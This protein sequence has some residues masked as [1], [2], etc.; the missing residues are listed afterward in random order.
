MDRAAMKVG[1]ETSL[2]ALKLTG[3]VL[4]SGED[5]AGAKEYG[6]GAGRRAMDLTGRIRRLATAI[7]IGVVV[8]LL[9]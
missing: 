2:G 8:P 3:F 7:G 9:V 4:K 5:F 1:G 6:T